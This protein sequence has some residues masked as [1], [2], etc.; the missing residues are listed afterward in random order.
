MKSYA[1]PFAIAGATL[2]AALLV[3]LNLLTTPGALWFIYP[4][5]ALVWW[6]AGV[7][8]CRRKKYMA[9]SAAGSLLTIAFLAA[10]NMITSPQTLWFLYAVPPLLCWPVAMY[11]K[12]T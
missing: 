3:V 4:V 5:F 1:T 8:L 11:Y 7:Y 10:V 2:T 6:P 9:F 12:R